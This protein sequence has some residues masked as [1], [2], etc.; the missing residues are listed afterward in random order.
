[1]VNNLTDQAYLKILNKIIDLDY[2]P[3]KKISEKNV[4][5][6]LGIGRTPVRE[7]LLR[8]KQAG[9]INVVPQSGTYV[10]LIELNRVADAIF[11]RRNLEAAI[12]QEACHIDF[13]KI[14]Y[15]RMLHLI[16]EQNQAL[17]E[18]SI[19]IFF[20]YFDQFHEQFF[21]KTNHPM[22]WKWL[23]DI[24]IYFYRLVVLS[25]KTDQVNWHQVID[26]DKRILEAV[27]NKNE[28][29][30]AEFFDA[31][32]TISPAREKA[33]ILQYRDYFDLK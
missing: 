4:E 32:I 5:K 12:M 18:D 15:D 6:D 13:S 11:L 14:E 10:S 28:K 29:E 23:S 19:S 33:L 8:L 3:G 24:N 26:Y 20:N 17:K 2:E 30:V 27:M 1:M 7:A 31:E 9:L 16:E 22:I 25:L 21:I